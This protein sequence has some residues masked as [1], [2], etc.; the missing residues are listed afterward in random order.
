MDFSSKAKTGRTQ[1]LEAEIY[2]PSI[3]K[4]LTAQ[5]NMSIKFSLE[6]NYEIFSHEKLLE[7]ICK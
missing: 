1:L 7:F 6:I 4:Y 5:S 2:E 3:I